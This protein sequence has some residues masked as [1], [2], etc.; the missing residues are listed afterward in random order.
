MLSSDQ[1]EAL[2]EIANVGLGQAG[3]AIA[4]VLNHFVRLSIPK[5]AMVGPHQVADSIPGLARGDQVSAVRQAFHSSMRGEAVCVYGGQGCRDLAELMGTSTPEDDASEIELL[6]DITNVLVGAC[7]GSIARQLGSDIGF[8]PPSLVAAKIPLE[9]LLNLSEVSWKTALLMEVSFEL[10]KRSFA[11][12]ILM[13]VPE[14]EI[15][16]LQQ[17]LDAFLAAL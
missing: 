11:C 8:T 16:A 1:Q 5:V 13:I 3:S 12:H 2:Q 10:E 4:K 14:R 6:L 7:L 9:K 15:E 17:V